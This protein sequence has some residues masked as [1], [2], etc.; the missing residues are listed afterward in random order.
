[1]RIHRF[2]A[3]VGRDLGQHLIADKDEIVGLRV[4]HHLL[5]RMAGAGDHFEFTAADLDPFLGDETQKG[6][7]RRGDHS[8]IL[9]PVAKQKLRAF[10][11]QPMRAVETAIG[12][13]SQSLWIEAN[14]K[15][16]QIFRFA[17]RKLQ[18]EALAQPPG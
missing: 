6:F 17:H 14:V 8:Q 16:D 9:Q 5:G 12:L 4:E 10:L 2:D 1:M 7:R 3:D 13:R 15:R 11:S 18:A